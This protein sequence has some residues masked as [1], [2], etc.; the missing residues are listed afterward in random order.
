MKITK[1]NN[2]LLN[3]TLLLLILTN[4]FSSFAQDNTLTDDE[5]SQGWKLL[6]N[7]KDMSQWRNFKK[8]DINDKWQVNNGTMQL[9]G[10]GGGDILT[11]D[12]YQDFDLRLEW[13]ISNAG[14]SGIF[15]LADETGKKI[16]SHAVEIQILDNKRHADNKIDSHLSGSIYDMIASPVE[17]RRP[18]GLWNQVRILLNQKQLTVWQNNIQTADINIGGEQWQALV[19]KSK[20]K[21]WEGF[22]LSNVGHIGLQDH[23][24]NVSFK[25]IKIKAL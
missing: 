19:A 1:T 4:P 8:H 15:I 13:K 20:F 5:K 23:G 25:N 12:I 9:T 3:L 2:K 24:D 10:V 6:F 7:G 22:A 17:S 18:A 11:N 14:N 16:Y 21:D